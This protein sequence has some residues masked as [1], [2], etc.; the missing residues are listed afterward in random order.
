MN[1]GSDRGTNESATGDTT[2]GTTAQSGAETGAQTAEETQHVSKAPAFIKARKSLHLS[3]Q[4]GVFIVGLAVIAAGVAMLVLP[5]PGWVAIFAGLAI[6]ATEFAWAHLVL[7]WTKRKVTEA[8]Q[9]ALDPKVRRRNIILT[10]AGLVIAGALIG[11]YLWKYGLVL[12]WDL[13]DQ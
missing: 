2:T 9:R 7:R 12:P 6:W 10:T 11:F 1:T 8:A 13:K 5:G 4:V 3:W